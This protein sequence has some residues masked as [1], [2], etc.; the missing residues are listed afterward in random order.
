MWLPTHVAGLGSSLLLGL[1]LDCAEA[2]SSVDYLSEIRD[3]ESVV[4]T[5]VPQNGAFCGGGFHPKNGGTHPSFTLPRKRDAQV[6]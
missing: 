3:R 4:E 1:P 6:V 5:D 2:P